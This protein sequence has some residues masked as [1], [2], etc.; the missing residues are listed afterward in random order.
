MSTR[1]A[2]LSYAQR[3]RRTT[4][5]GKT[6][7]MIVTYHEI[8]ERS[9]PYVYSV[10]FERFREHVDYLRES[11]DGGSH[12]ITFD[13]GLCE[14][15]RAG[16]VLEAAGF[17]GAFFITPSWTG[18]AGFMDRADL[19]SLQTAGHTI[20][21]HGWSHELLAG[22][23]PDKLRLELV[24]SK[25]TL[26]DWLGRE[27]TVLA[28]PGGAYDRRALRAAADAGYTVV[29]TSDPWLRPKRRQGLLMQGR[30]MIRNS[31]TVEKLQSLLA[32]ED[33]V[34]SWP[35]LAYALRRCMRN[36]LGVPLYHKL[37]VVA[38]RFEETRENRAE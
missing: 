18:T 22:C 19:L 11:R 36:T 20:G 29:Y 8:V 27:V 4:R 33:R 21:S 3:A 14:H 30:L 12:P 17:R 1:P 23:N 31:T 13:D 32:T 2:A 28:F 6:S 24:R 35:K 5:S 26:E 10:H 16:D 15:R 38:A 37:W 9:S 7:S 34:L 25:A